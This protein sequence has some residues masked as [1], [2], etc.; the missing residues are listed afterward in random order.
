MKLKIIEDSA[1]EPLTIVECRSHLNVYAYDTD[2][3]NVAYHPDDDMILAMLASAREMCENFMGRA[4]KRRKY[5]LALDQFPF[6]NPQY[7]YPYNAQPDVAGLTGAIELP[8]APL[9]TVLSINVGDDSDALMVEDT[10]Y[11]VDDYSTPARIVPVSTWPSV[12]S[13][14]NQIKI[15]YIAGYGVDSDG[16][17]PLPYAI[18]SAI[19]LTLGTL[20]ANRENE[21]IATGAALKLSSGVE[22]MLRPY[23]IR[24]GMA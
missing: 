7:A 5:E 24:L 1:D 16:N 20:Y 22:S 23:R 6:S 19:M 17:K 18:R 10:D 8:W 13:S 12:T 21:V 3:D 11:L 15:Q 14:L 4:I 2:S 9:V